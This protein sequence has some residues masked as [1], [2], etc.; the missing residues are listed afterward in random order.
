MLDD[1]SMQHFIVTTQFCADATETM[2]LL[3]HCLGDSVYLLDF[4][5]ASSPQRQFGVAYNIKNSVDSFFWF[6]FLSI[7]LSYGQ[8]QEPHH[9]QPV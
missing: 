2:D 7:G 8:V 6:L 3:L 9:S 1:K 5:P 4:Y